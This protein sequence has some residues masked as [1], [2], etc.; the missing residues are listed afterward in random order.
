V[1]HGLDGPVEV[2]GEYSGKSG[3]DKEQGQQVA[4]QV[5]QILPQKDE[6]QRGKSPSHFLFNINFSLILLCFVEWHFFSINVDSNTYRN[7]NRTRS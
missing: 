1:K 4:L 2:R 6:E 3:A 5:E 7:G